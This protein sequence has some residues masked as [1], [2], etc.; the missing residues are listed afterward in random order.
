M[1]TFSRAFILLAALGFHLPASAA[2]IDSVYTELSGP[3]CKALEENATEGWAKGRCRGTAGYMLDWSEGDLRQTLNVIDPKGRDFPLELWSTVASG[4]SSL[5]DKAEWRVKKVGKQASPIALIVRYNVSEDPEKPEKTT[6]Y[7]TVSK[8]TADEV[9]VTDV[10][11]PGSDANTKARELADAAASKPCQ[12]AGDDGQA[13]TP[14]DA[15]PPYLC[16]ADEQVI[17]GCTSKDKMISLCA[18]PDVSNT[19]GHMQYRFGTPGKIELAYPDK[20]SAPKGNFMHSF[21]P[22]SGGYSERVRFENGKV[23]YVIFEDMISTGAGSAEKEM[24]RGVGILMPG[25]KATSRLCD[26]S[27]TL[28]DGSGEAKGFVFDHEKMDLGELLDKEDF[29]FDLEL[30]Q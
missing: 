5:G 2:T 22:Y 28:S 29:N 11:K 30:H 9:C 6:S 21:E 14:T 27:G 1:R 19:G 26:G 15:T 13:Q 10:V 25:K 23:Q 17:F 12:S 3:N 24:H 20:Q 16:E 8:I 7:L 18:S 4:F